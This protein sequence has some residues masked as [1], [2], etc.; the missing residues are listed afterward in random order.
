[1]VKRKIKKTI[2]LGISKLRAIPVEP[3]S[4]QE[5]TED[6][7]EIENTKYTAVT[8]ESPEDFEV[9]GITIKKGEELRYIL[10]VVL[11]PESIDGTRTEKTIG[12]IY[13][14]DEVRKAAHNFM[15]NYSGT[16]NDLMHNGRDN[17]KLKIVESYIAPSDMLVGEAAV[18]KGTWMMATLVLDDSIWKSVKNGE[19]TGFSIGGY[20][21]ARLES[22]SPV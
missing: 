17:P 6:N 4:K 20:S 12:D 14:E 7:Y 5:G 11:E 15:A 19:I 10:G 3:K 13:N 16:D 1:M 18:K 2:D 21:E 8:Y 22:P 9:D